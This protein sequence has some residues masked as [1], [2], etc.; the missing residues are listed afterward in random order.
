LVD[1]AEVLFVDDDV[2][3]DTNENALPVLNT[4]PDSPETSPTVV[5]SMRAHDNIRLLALR[6]IRWAARR[7]GAAAYIFRRWLLNRC[8]PDDRRP[9]QSGVQDANH[10]AAKCCTIGGENLTTDYLAHDGRC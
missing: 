6:Y 9:V 3:F 2:R 5:E 10:A 7:D 4:A 1:A 8:G